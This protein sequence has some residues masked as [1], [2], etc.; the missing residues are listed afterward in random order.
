MHTLWGGIL[1]PLEY[2]HQKM[3][4]FPLPSHSWQVRQ[5]SLVLIC[6]LPR[7]AGHVFSATV[8]RLLDRVAYVPEERWV[9]YDHD[10]EQ[11]QQHVH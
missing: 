11:D 5:P 6:P 7:Q 10:S 8:N 3:A 1:F 9:L 4:T 2:A